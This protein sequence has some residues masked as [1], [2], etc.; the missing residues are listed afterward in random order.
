MKLG[1]IG[2]AG[3]LGSTTAFYAGVSGH[4]EEIKLLD[5]KDN[6]VMSHVMDMDQAVSTLSATKI[7]KAAYSDL[8]DCDIVL[9]SASLP[10][11]NVANR[12][13]YL[14]GNLGL[15]VDIC[16]NLKKHTDMRDKIVI[17]AS[18]PVDVF[19][20]VVWKLLGTKREKT[21]GFCLNDSVRFTW[22]I[23]KTLG[24]PYAAIDACCIGEHGEGQVPLFS[25]V[26]VDGKTRSFPPEE[27]ETIRKTVATWFTEYQ[28]L[29]SGR[30]SGWTSA[31]G[32]ARMINAVASNSGEVM[33]CS[34]VLDGEFG[35]RE[36]SIGVPVSLGSAGCGEFL[37]PPID[38]AEK[39]GFAAAADKIRS[40]IHSI[41]F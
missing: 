16:D 36:L 39:A 6:M 14:K 13:E 24:R 25:Q 31:V 37:L 5:I 20:Y 30:T 41:G 7:S 12:N 11:R 15:I 2:G 18:N 9:I 33:S 35:Q 40:L 1:I 29:Q 27:R 23:G 38:D 4:L 26:K 10:E 22:A 19:N 28:A 32:L 17:N 34:M 21:L 3:L 8:G